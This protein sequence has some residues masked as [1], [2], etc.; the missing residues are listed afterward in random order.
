MP[1]HA[2][3]TAQPAALP[4]DRQQRVTAL[5]L[6]AVV[7]SLF[8]LAQTI[9]YMRGVGMLELN[10][11]ARVMVELGGARQLVMF[12][13]F[14]VAVGCGVLYLLRRHALAERCAWVCVVVLVCLA[15]WWMRYNMLVVDIATIADASQL[16]ADPRWVALD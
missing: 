1:P 11:L 10:P 14:T 15:L 13:M 9:T 4:F 3:D 8:D 5:V 7:L 2:I 12:K 16:A 6:M